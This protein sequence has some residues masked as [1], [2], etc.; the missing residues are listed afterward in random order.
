MSSLYP[1]EF[2]A[3]CLGDSYRSAQ[4]IV[5]LVLELFPGTQSVLDAG[6][7]TGHS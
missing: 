5:P 6:C 1:P 4:K 3:N 2:F 7:G